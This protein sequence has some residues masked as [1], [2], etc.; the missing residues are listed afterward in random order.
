[1]KAF[2]A[3]ER[4]ARKQHQVGML[5]ELGDSKELKHAISQLETI[6]KEIQVRSGPLQQALPDSEYYAE[7]RSVA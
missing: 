6:E 3:N 5:K 2:H 4:L 1:M 7:E